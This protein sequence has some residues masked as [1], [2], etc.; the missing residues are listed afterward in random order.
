MHKGALILLDK[1][2]N[3]HISKEAHLDIIEI[4]SLDVNGSVSDLLSKYPNLK[5]TGADIEAGKNVDIVVDLEYQW[6]NIDDQSFDI[7]FSNQL[8][9]HVEMPWELVKSMD[10]ILKPNGLMIHVVPCMRNEHKFP[11]DCWRIMPDGMLALMSDT[12]SYETLTCGNTDVDTF[13]VGK[14]N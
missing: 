7:A 4:G 13:Y 14:K 5:D 12:L 2:F 10:R 9:E 1:L 11:I 6:S 3:E 8:L